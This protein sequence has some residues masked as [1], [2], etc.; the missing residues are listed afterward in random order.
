MNRMNP[1]I[2]YI[3]CDGTV[4]NGSACSRFLLEAFRLLRNALGSCPKPRP[5]FPP[6]TMIHFNHW[7]WQLLKLCRDSISNTVQIEHLIDF[8]WWFGAVSWPLPYVFKL[9]SREW[10]GEVFCPR[11]HELFCVPP[12]SL[13]CQHR[14]HPAIPI[15]FYPSNPA[16]FCIFVSRALLLN[17]CN[18]YFRNINLRLFLRP[19]HFAV[20]ISR[21]YRNKSRHW[22]ASGFSWVRY[23]LNYDPRSRSVILNYGIE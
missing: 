15:W 3:T 13:C 16:R 6:A 2:L 8:C 4:R 21:P 14:P 23:F 12:P 20:K 1:N 11:P 17:A 7:L 9:G 19:I 18:A 5:T 10:H 22:T